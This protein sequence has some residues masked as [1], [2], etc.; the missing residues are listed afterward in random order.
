[1][2]TGRY[3]SDLQVGDDLES[4]DY[5]MTPFVVREYCHGIGEYREEF[6]SDRPLG[7]QLVPPTLSHI[8][9]IRLLQRNCPD[10]PGPSARIHYRFQTWHHGLVE[11][12]SR[13]RA[14]G[15]VSARDQR[16][17]RTHLDMDIEVVE[18]DTG[19][20]VIECRDTAILSYSGS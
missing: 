11:V 6:H 16:K 8:D 1:M 2:S 19:R 9:K 13:L 7:G 15:R 18:T 4:V 14:R 17:R 12:G 20:V 3:V 5:I 10:G